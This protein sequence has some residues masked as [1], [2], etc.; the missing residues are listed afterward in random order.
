MKLTTW[1]VYLLKNIHNHTTASFSTA[2]QSAS[3]VP[4]AR[5]NQEKK[6]GTH[7]KLYCIVKIIKLWRIKD[8]L[9]LSKKR[10]ILSENT[11]DNNSI[12]EKKSG[13]VEAISLHY[14][15]S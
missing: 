13:F 12:H 6:E 4:S 2:S 1:H 14:S 10:R 7:S 3:Y 11:D 9:L 15:N 5:Y 8:V